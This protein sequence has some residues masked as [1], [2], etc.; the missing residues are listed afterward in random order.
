MDL[1]DP[2]PK[3]WAIQ[4]GLPLRNHYVGVCLESEMGCMNLS[5][6]YVCQDAL[7]MVKLP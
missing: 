4:V 7:N 3:A 5:I 1:L 2:G 6:R